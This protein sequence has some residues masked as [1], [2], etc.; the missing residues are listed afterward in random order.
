M[1]CETSIRYTD[2]HGFQLWNRN[3]VKMKRR[4]IDRSMVKL[5]DIVKYV[6]DQISRILYEFQSPV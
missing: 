5:V 3:E 2:N 1:E 6:Y 4:R